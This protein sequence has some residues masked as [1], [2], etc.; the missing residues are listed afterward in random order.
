MYAEQR[1]YFDLVGSAKRQDLVEITWIDQE[2][3]GLKVFSFDF[4]YR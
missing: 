3:F 2:T 1:D 4:H